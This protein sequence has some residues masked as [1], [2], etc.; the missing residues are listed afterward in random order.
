MQPDGK[1]FDNI[2]II[3]VFPD[4]DC[5][6]IDRAPDDPADEGGIF[7][8]SGK[9]VFL[10]WCASGAGAS[11]SLFL[12][13]G[14]MKVPRESLEIDIVILSLTCRHSDNIGKTA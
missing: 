6:A 3:V 7:D 9:A 12:K 13:H 4:S 5:F 11:V 8:A 1:Y 2:F 14:G 10:G